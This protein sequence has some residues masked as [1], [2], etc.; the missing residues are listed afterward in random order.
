MGGS[1]APKGE[2]T[3]D[4]V[5]LRPYH[6]CRAGDAPAGGGRRIPVCGR[7]DQADAAAEGRRDP[8]GPSLS[9]ASEVGC[10]SA[11]TDLAG[12]TRRTRCAEWRR[13]VD[14]RRTSRALDA[15]MVSCDEL[16]AIAL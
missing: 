9:G 5:P 15:A 1:R 7:L 10:W 8:R 16:G 14:A 13:F 6:A 12:Q 11:G 3:E 2:G 4:Q